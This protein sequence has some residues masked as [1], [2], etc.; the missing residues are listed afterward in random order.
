M[1]RPAIVGA[2]I[3]KDAR[4]YVRD[5]LWLFLTVL[6]LVFLIV[7]FWLLPN[8]VD[9][10]ITVGIS[11]ISGIDALVVQAPGG[12]SGDA[13]L[14]AVPIPDAAALR[15]VVAG[16]RKAWR[17]EAGSLVIAATE[18]ERVPRGACDGRRD[19]LGH[20]RRV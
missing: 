17:D 2:I 20:G 4:E 16:E 8:R 12:A 6:S 3:A 10:S 13:G 9:E 18:D 7:I 15:A 1:S 14:A 5:R 19:E 11:G